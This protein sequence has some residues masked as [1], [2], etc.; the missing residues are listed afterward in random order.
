MKATSLR[1]IATHLPGVTEKPYRDGTSFRFGGHIIAT[2]WEKKEESYIKL[3]PIQQQELIAL[4]PQAFFAATKSWGKDGWTGVKL[5]EVKRS[6]LKKALALSM[7]N[8]SPA[9][10]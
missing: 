5:D 8:F 4:N 10:S 7:G 1:E 9:A 3:N 6:E 2:L